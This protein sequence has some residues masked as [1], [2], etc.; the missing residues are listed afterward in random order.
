MNRWLALSALCLLVA[1]VQAAERTVSSAAD[2]ERLAA[3]ARP[4]DVLVM[5]D[6]TWKDELITLRSSGL[7]LP[8]MPFRLP[9]DNAP[10]ESLK[11]GRFSR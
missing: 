7:T 1:N 10:F 4:G 5:I 9:V 8:T 11:L 3:D 2:I 6:G